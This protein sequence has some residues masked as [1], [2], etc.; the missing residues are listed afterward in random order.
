MARTKQTA[1]K[2]TGGM[3]PRRQPQ[4]CPSCGKMPNEHP[5][6][7]AAREIDRA[8]IARSLFSEHFYRSAFSWPRVPLSEFPSVS[9]F[10]CG[11]RRRFEYHEGEVL[12]LNANSS[13]RP[14]DAR[15]PTSDGLVAR[16]SDAVAELIYAHFTDAKELLAGMFP[17]GTLVA[18]GGALFTAITSARFPIFEDLELFFVGVTPE[19]AEEM[20]H[21]ACAMFER[22]H[23]GQVRYR[24]SQNVTEVVV[25]QD[26]ARAG[27]PPWRWNRGQNQSGAAPASGRRY[28]FIHRVYPSAEHVI[29]GFDLGP[30]MVCFDGR[31]V[32]ST[33]FGAWS[34]ANKCI[35]VDL[36]RRST[37]FEARI[38]KYA[39]RGC[40]VL[41]AHTTRKEFAEELAAVLG[42]EATASN[43]NVTI[44]RGLRVGSRSLRCVLAPLPQSVIS[45]YDLEETTGFG[46]A[47]ALL[48]DRLDCVS[49]TGREPGDILGS[50]PDRD[51][52]RHIN[53]TLPDV[54]LRA[55]RSNIGGRYLP[56]RVAQTWLAEATVKGHGNR[57]GIRVATETIAKRVA[58]LGAQF[59]QKLAVN[60]A[61]WKPVWIAENPGRQWTSSHNPVCGDVR[62][63]YKFF[64]RALVIGIPHDVFFTVRCAALPGPNRENETSPLRLLPPDAVRLILAHVASGLARDGTATLLG[65]YAPPGEGEMPRDWHDLANS[66]SMRKLVDEAEQLGNTGVEK[67]AWIAERC[68]DGDGDGAAVVVSRQ[69][70]LSA[71][72]SSGDEG[73][74]FEL[75][76]ATEPARRLLDE[77]RYSGRPLEPFHD[78]GLLTF[79]T[80][81]DLSLERFGDVERL[82]RELTS[83]VK[84]FARGR[85]AEVP[86]NTALLGQL[87]GHLRAVAFCL[88]A[89]TRLLTDVADDASGSVPL[90]MEQIRDAFATMKKAGLTELSLKI[91][92][93][94]G[95]SSRSGG[96]ASEEGGEQQ[97]NSE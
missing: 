93:R 90:A 88:D 43:P 36:S 83:A 84:P 11:N 13:F 74:D 15:R 34:V 53:F 28:Q 1:R 73:E 49:W 86:E 71:E 81:I 57:W 9:C 54:L 25:E 80:S 47:L 61:S 3:A 16:T 58:E 32:F 78:D 52:H 66:V 63:W 45:D 31:D 12:V 46:N 14:A 26:D 67:L 38:R 21:Q 17:P 2:S 35:M 85:F 50:D 41:L 40:S 48:R 96:A 91:G 94:G 56:I 59:E 5:E 29:G 19:T 18:A 97:G 95:S 42:P 64:R 10:E 30:S 6:P 44:A 55:A 22:N 37:T 68:G 33:P 7:P 20:V 75:V 70:V 72:L 39:S 62:L 69:V 27:K 8:F 89:I 4:P 65:D 23:P 76:S 60:A 87:C 51:H 24:R 92:G 79:L 82:L 77:W